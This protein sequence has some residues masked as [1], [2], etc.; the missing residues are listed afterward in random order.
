M[1]SKS[2]S[3]RYN[4]WFGSI[5]SQAK[6]LSGQAGLLPELYYDFLY[7]DGRRTAIAMAGGGSSFNDAAQCVKALG[8]ARLVPAYDAVSG[9]YAISFDGGKFSVDAAEYDEDGFVHF[10]ETLGREYVLT[11]SFVGHADTVTLLVVEEAQCLAVGRLG[12][13]LSTV[14][15]VLGCICAVTLAG[16]DAFRIV[17]KGN[18]F[19]L[20]RFCKLPAL[21]C[22]APATVCGG[23]ADG[24]V[25][26]AFAL[27]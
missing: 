5:V 9:G 2:Y 1:E 23:V 22:H 11:E 19:I 27:V 8:R 25:D 13:Y 26:Y 17:S 14:E 16:S 24:I 10:L 15:Q 3:Y 18:C 4:A 12:K 6:L 21:P 20:Y 7:R